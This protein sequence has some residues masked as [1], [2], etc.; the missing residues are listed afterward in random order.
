MAASTEAMVVERTSAGT[1]LRFAG[2]L[3]VGV[4][5]RLWS[6]ALR[7]AAKL[8]GQKLTLDL[9]AV[10]VCDTAGATLLL[11]IERLQGAPVAITGA[12]EKVAA[13]LA[14]TR[15]ATAPPARPVAAVAQDWR[16]VLSEAVAVAV[17]EGVAFLGE[18]VVAG[19]GCRRGGGCIR[20]RDLLRQT[21]GAG[22][23][24]IPLVIA[25]GDSDGADPGVPVAAFR[26]GSSAPRSMSCRIWWRSA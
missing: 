18:V 16:A 22:V 12:G 11:E 13:V 8:R 5:A 21:D 6:R 4:T 24:A 25:A 15:A 19:C 14:Q 7:E 10:P 17:G 1:V 23:Q 2:P 20:L 26:C 9:A 3:D